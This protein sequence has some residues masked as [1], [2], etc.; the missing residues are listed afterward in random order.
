MDDTSYLKFVLA[1]IFVISIL[2]LLSMLLKKYGGF[3]PSM[4]ASHKRRLKIIEILPLEYRKRL[5]L[6]ECDGEEHLI[7]SGQNHDL[8]IKSETITSPS[9]ADIRKSA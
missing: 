5:V 7:L 8:L 4:V 1:L 2:G 9:T 3:G 6:I